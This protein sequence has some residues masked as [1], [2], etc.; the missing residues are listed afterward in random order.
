M[1]KKSITE[2]KVNKVNQPSP[3]D[4][5]PALLLPTFVLNF[6]PKY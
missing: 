1:N 6:N 5:G 2:N 3:P 4:C